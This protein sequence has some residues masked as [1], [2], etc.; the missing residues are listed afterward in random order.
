[1]TYVLTSADQEQ[2]WDTE[3]ELDDSLKREKGAIQALKKIIELTDNT[4]SRCKT[5][6]SNLMNM[7][8]DKQG[9]AKH[10]LEVSRE[11]LRKETRKLMD[12][13]FLPDKLNETRKLINMTNLSD[14][15]KE[16]KNLAEILDSF[17]YI[18]RI[19]HLT[20]RIQN[21]STTVA[22]TTNSNLTDATTEKPTLEVTVFYL[23]PSP[24]ED[25]DM[26]S[27]VLLQDE[28]KKKKR[29]A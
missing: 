16:T 27:R 12:I 9:V 25:R 17:L 8:R 11:N 28:E 26:S 3:K 13:L 6:L 18:P 7:L 21:V 4:V 10:Q 20:E 1:M 2:F 22:K 29:Q 23:E 14:I 19:Q 5:N 15:E 24:D